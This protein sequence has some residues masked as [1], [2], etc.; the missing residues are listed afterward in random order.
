MAESNEHVEE[1]EEEVEETKVEKPKQDDE[2]PIRQKPWA[3]RTERAQF[4]KSKKKTEQGEG[5]EGGDEEKTYSLGEVRKILQE[6]LAP[7]SE[8]IS[9]AQVETDIRTY[10][11]SNPALQKFE[12]SARRWMEAHPTLTAES[13]FALASRGKVSEEKIPDETRK[14]DEEKVIRGS[15]GGGS[16]VRKDPSSLPTTEA[17]Q[18]KVLAEVM[19][20]KTVK[21]GE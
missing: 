1:V 11:S 10:V 8:V 17:E 9:K 19:K 7:F 20:G 12:A 18:K 15:I 13:A 14:K 5:E 4:F 16:G 21:L 3:N 2:V 6:E